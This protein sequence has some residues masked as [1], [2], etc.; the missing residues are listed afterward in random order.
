MNYFSKLVGTGSG[1]PE[2]IVTNKELEAFVDTN[3]EWIR[4][5]TGIQARHM[6]D[7]TKG[8]TTVS[9]AEAA[10]RQALKA[11]GMTGSELEMIVVGTVTPDTVMPCVANQVQERLGATKAFSFDL[12][13]ACSGFIYGLSLA[14]SQIRT[15][16]VRTALVIGAETLSSLINWND[17]T[18]C[19]L[20]GDG[21]GAAILQRSEDPAHSIVGTQI[22]AD[23]R[24][25]DILAIP[26]GYSKV[27]PYSEEYRHD[28]H[29]IHMQGGEVFKLAVRHMV[30]SSQELLKKH[31]FGIA[32][33]DHFV[34]HQA[35]IRIIDMCTKMLSIPPEKTSI[36][37]QKY[38]NTS[39]ATLPVC[40]DEA[41]RAGKVKPG[42][43][44]LL[45][46][47]GGGIT[48][49]SALIRI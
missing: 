48:W 15:G 36:N 34:F 10:A 42:N 9:F 26:H 20:F 30:E 8:E 44:V 14:D 7:R 43:L 1:F 3:D 21:A 2:R 24:H 6:A 41:I 32:D 49:G 31:G 47:F 35:N 18:T 25:G 29:K 13:A 33:V 39:S 45:S 22:Y 4:T 17:R 28:M 40:L 11:A 12:S 38:G 16:Q 23:G 37:V 19:V 27:P 5:R 46:T